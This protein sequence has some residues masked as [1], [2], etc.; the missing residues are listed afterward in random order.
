MHHSAHS[1]T[2]MAYNIKNKHL[3]SYT[4]YNNICL[5]NRQTWMALALQPYVAFN[6]DPLWKNLAQ[7]QT[8][9]HWVNDS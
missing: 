3:W 2:T 6:T 9:Y 1:H 8:F 4:K 5:N 7:D